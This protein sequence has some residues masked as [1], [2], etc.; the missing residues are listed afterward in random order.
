MI[1]GISRTIRNELSV[2][3]AVLE[4]DSTGPPAWEATVKTF[5][6]LQRRST[7]SSKLDC[8]YEFVLVNGHVNI[9]RFHWLSVRKEL[10]KLAL[11][12]GLT[13]QK[14]L[15]IG[16]RGLLQ[17]LQW[18]QQPFRDVAADKVE[19]EVRAAG[20]N[21]KVSN[22]IAVAVTTCIDIG[23]K[24]VLIAVGIVDGRPDEGNSLGCECAGVVRK[25][26]A[27]VQN[28]QVGDRVMLLGGGGSL[29]TSIQIP[30]RVCIK[31]S[32][33]LSF[34]DAA[35]MPCVYITAIRSLLDIG[36]LQK[37]QVSER[38]SDQF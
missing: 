13:S 27:N 36:R 3:F 25:I 18:V 14:R 17:T 38:Y 29:G 21:F 4:L 8:D 10:S 24:D 33:Q 12:T 6:K 15:E 16:R 30:S 19:V 9:G 1:V 28:V 31:L 26:G 37:G 2:P 7:D 22:L 5:E 23:T 11:E 34:E 35:T 20:M 32:E